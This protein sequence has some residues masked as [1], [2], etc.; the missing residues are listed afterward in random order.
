MDW[1]ERLTALRLKTKGIKAGVQI[2]SAY[3]KQNNERS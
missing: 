3:K 2:C 1:E